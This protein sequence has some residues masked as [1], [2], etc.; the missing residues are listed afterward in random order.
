MSLYNK[1]I[2][3]SLNYLTQ[4]GDPD[5]IL[6]DEASL[7]AVG[8]RG[9]CGICVDSSGNVYVSDSLRH[10]II[11]ISSAGNVYLYAGKAGERGNNGRNTV[12]L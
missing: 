1:I 11:K 9:V 12:S 6:A 5:Y 7:S 4:A 3:R 10:I 2:K 8:S